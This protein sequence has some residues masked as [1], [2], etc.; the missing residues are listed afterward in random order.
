LKPGESLQALGRPQAEAEHEF[1]ELRFLDA[2]S[3]RPLEGV[4]VE[5][6]T[7]PGAEPGFVETRIDD[8]RSALDGSVR[9]HWRRGE[10]HGEKLRISKAGYESQ[11]CGPDP[12]E[13]LLCP[14]QALR[15]RVL[16][17]GLRPVAGATVR[18]RQ[19]CAHAISASETRTQS[20]GT[21][22][23]ED[24]PIGGTPE[25][26]VFADG[27]SARGELDAL[28]LRQQ[29]EDARG[30]GEPGCTLL[31]ARCSAWPLRLLDADGRP[32]AH[33]RVWTTERPIVACS[34]AADGA[35]EFTLPVGA[36]SLY[37]ETCDAGPK[38]SFSIP[39]TPRTGVIR[40][41][42]NDPR[43]LA[44]RAGRPLTSVRV[45]IAAL[46]VSAEAML[47]VGVFTEDGFVFGDQD[48]RELLVPRGKARIVVVGE[49]YEYVGEL[50]VEVGEQ[51]LA[52]EIPPPAAAP[53]IA[54][55]M[56]EFHEG[57]QLLTQFGSRTEFGQPAPPGDEKSWIVRSSPGATPGFALYE[58]SGAVRVAKLAADSARFHEPGCEIVPALASHPRIS[59][60]WRGKGE[61]G[62]CAAQNGTV[63]PALL[64]C[65]ELSGSAALELPE[66]RLYYA[67]FWAEGA[68]P[69]RVLRR[70]RAGE[71]QGI[72]LVR[73]AHVSIAGD[74][75]APEPLVLD[76]APGPLQV[77]IVHRDGT[78]SMLSLQL[79]PGEQRALVVE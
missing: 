41:R 32:L 53:A 9:V 25:L 46:H 58:R 8:A 62:L 76:P 29:A 11:Q 2:T 66:G 55:A 14:A 49:C 37:L 43:P 35:C 17:L 33:R 69:R 26:E 52:I 51:P 77:R 44:E 6:W 38:L 60:P 65:P 5:A 59:V 68:V 71:D 74:V 72:D 3:S 34:T 78:A 61:N 63:W 1:I 56:P 13:F 39:M 22:V 23:L 67:E 73:R 42:A 15:G 19:S 48:Y 4:R 27:F 47:R 18:S 7:E 12:G 57:D 31:L 50:A 16:D 75:V 28:E 24:F 20:D 79:A 40:V 36:T 30:R 10:Q 64:P 45:S 21:F 70:A 54:L